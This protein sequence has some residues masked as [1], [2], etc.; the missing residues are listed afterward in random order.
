MNQLLEAYPDAGNYYDA[1]CLYSLMGEGEQAVAYLRKAFEVGYRSLVHI[2]Q[3][4]DL[5]AIRGRDDFK[6]LLLQY[7]KEKVKSLLEQL[8]N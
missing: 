2:A 8:K 3:D 4:N 5:D 7:Q 6:E 1:A